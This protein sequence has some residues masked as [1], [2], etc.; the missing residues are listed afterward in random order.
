MMV[1]VEAIKHLYEFMD[2]E[3]DKSQYPTMKRAP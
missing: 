3:I 1:C 2:K